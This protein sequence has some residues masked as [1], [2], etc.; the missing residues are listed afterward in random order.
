MASA[1]PGESASTCP[2][3]HLG[4]TPARG[5]CQAAR[6]RSIVSAM[7]IGGTVL[8]GG[9]T[10]MRSTLSRQLSSG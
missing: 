1:W 7:S 5:R 10:V 3:G 9:A 2:A 6:A 8:E 4:L